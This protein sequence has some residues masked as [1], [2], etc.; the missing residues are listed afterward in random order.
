MLEM[1]SEDSDTASFS[2]LI[3]D[4]HYVRVLDSN[5]Q[6]KQISLLGTVQGKDA[7]ITLEK[8]HF[9]FDKVVNNPNS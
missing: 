6:T 7:I 1:S 3:N 8:T 2:S 9:Q 5:P 4:F